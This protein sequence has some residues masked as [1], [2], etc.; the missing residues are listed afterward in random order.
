MIEASADVCSAFI[1]VVF[2]G[3]V[4]EWTPPIEPGRWR[5]S[6]WPCPGR[7]ESTGLP[8]L[9]IVCS[10]GCHAGAFTHA[11]PEHAE[12]RTGVHPTEVLW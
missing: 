4:D 8:G 11:L 2:G 5:G 3:R 1:P 7:V 6:A 12:P 10:C 9:W